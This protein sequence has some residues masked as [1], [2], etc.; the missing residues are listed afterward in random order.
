MGAWSIIGNNDAL[1]LAISESG[2]STIHGTASSHELIYTPSP[3]T[4]GEAVI[5]FCEEL[6][7]LEFLWG[8]YPANAAEEL[9]DG[10][11]HGLYERSKNSPE[12]SHGWFKYFTEPDSIVAQIILP[13][14]TFKNVWPLFHDVLLEPNLVYCISLDFFGFKEEGA[15]SDIPT[16]KEFVNDKPYFTDEVSFSLRNKEK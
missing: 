10:T 16:I 4:H 11:E 1:A 7:G 5:K 15:V 8:I 2:H 12:S 9:N 6:S 3:T 14:A 13:P